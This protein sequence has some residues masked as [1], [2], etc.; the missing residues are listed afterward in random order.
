MWPL[1]FHCRA[2]LE[3]CPVVARAVATN[4]AKFGAHPADVA[5]NAVKICKQ[6]AAS[7]QSRL[8]CAPD[9]AR[10]RP[11]FFPMHAKGPKRQPATPSR[12]MVPCRGRPIEALDN[13]KTVLTARCQ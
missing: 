11:I 3:R 12:A 1:R 13:R 7:S 4:L 6:W 10:G 2:A 8:V 5:Q 9:L